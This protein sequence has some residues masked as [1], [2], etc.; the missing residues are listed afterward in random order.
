MK[1]TPKSFIFSGITSAITKLVSVNTAHDAIKITNENEAT[2]IQLYASMS[3]CHDFNIVYVPNTINPK[4]VPVELTANRNLR[5]K[6]TYLIVSVF[7]ERFSTFRPAR[8]TSCVETSAP[9]S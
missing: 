4:A 9:I 8:S 1:V 2:G 7:F 3:Y 6:M 5:K